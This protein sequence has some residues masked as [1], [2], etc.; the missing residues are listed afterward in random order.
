MERRADFLRQLWLLRRIGCTFCAVCRQQFLR[1]RRNRCVIIVIQVMRTM[2]T[3]DSWVWYHCMGTQL[4]WPIWT[5]R[6]QVQGAKVIIVPRRI[7]WSWLVHWPL[8][9]GLLHFGTARRPQPAQA[10]PRC[11]KCNRPSI[12]GQCTDHR[13]AVLGPLFCDFNVRIKGSIV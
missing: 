4:I 7:I 5:N 11:T 9:G 8:M 6:Y 12:I 3:L 13:I 2:K 10:P 1:F